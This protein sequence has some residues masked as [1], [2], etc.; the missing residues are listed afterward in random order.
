MKVKERAKHLCKLLVLKFLLKSCDRFRFNH[1][2]LETLSF[3]FNEK[4]PQFSPRFDKDKDFE[5][6][7]SNENSDEDDDESGES[8]NELDDDEWDEEDTSQ[9]SENEMD[10]GTVLPCSL[11]SIDC[12]NCVANSIP[13]TDQTP[14]CY[15]WKEPIKYHFGIG[16]S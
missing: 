1:V 9:S 4:T 12:S 2:L 11:D 10:E 16:E 8:D 5:E 6:Y 13:N 3:L 14:K 7:D 15:I